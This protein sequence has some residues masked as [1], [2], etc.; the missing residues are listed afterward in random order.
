M[1]SFNYPASMR[2]QQFL[3]CVGS[4]PLLLAVL[5]FALRCGASAF[6]YLPFPFQVTS[7]LAAHTFV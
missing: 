7:S 4:I 6:F 2:L 3:C 5:F 1:P